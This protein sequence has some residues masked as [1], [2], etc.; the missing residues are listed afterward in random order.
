MTGLAHSS[1]VSESGGSTGS[2][3]SP[4]SGGSGGSPGGSGGASSRHS[5]RSAV[6]GATLSVPVNVN[7]L[8]VERAGAVRAAS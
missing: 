8:R 6:A 2:G 1:Q 7:V 5:N 3:G 4:G